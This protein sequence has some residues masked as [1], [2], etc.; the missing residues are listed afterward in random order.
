MLPRLTPGAKLF[1]IIL[2]GGGF[3][4]IALIAY[5]LTPSASST[6][7]FRR[8]LPV[9]LNCDQHDFIF[10]GNGEDAKEHIQQLRTRH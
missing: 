10:E 4:L 2:F 8:A 9:R 1:L 7:H 5:M 6:Q 3:M